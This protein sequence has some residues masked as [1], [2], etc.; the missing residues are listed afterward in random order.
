MSDLYPESAVEEVLARTDILSVI[1]PYVHLVRKGGR[2]FG[3]CPFHQEKSPSF[4]VS[5]ERGLFYCFGCGAGG[6]VLQFL[7]RMEGWS[8][9]EALEELAR[10]A[11]VRLARPNPEEQRRRDRRRS[12]QEAYFGLTEMATTFFQQ[13]L[14]GGHSPQANRYLAERGVDEE[15]ARLFRLGYAPDGW[16]HLLRFLRRNNLSERAVEAAGLAIPRRSGGYYDRFRDRIVF[17]VIDTL[18]RVVGFSARALGQVEEQKYINSPDLP[19]FKKGEQLFG[20]HAAKEHFRKEGEA[21][22]VEGNFDVVTL[23]AAG[24]RT[25]VAPLGTA[26]TAE[27]TRLLSRLVDSAVV[28]FDGDEAGRRAMMRCLEP[29]YR[30]GLAVRAALLPADTDPDSL[31]KQQGVEPFRALLQYARPLAEVVL[32]RA[33]TEAVG[34]SLEERMQAGRAA[35]ELLGLLPEGGLRRGYT[36]EVARRLDLP[37]EEVAAGIKPV[38]AQPAAQSGPVQPLSDNDR[39]WIQLVV[40]L[41]ALAERLVEDQPFWRLLHPAVHQL[42]QLLVEQG[43]AKQGE[44]RIDRLVERLDETTRSQILQAIASPQLHSEGQAEIAFEKQ[45]RKLKLDYLHQSKKKLAEQMRAAEKAG[46]E[47]RFAELVERDRDLTQ[48]LQAVK[49]HQP[50]L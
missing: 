49:R 48:E 4:S 21:V 32:D 42:A 43:L 38:K 11:G 23:H 29:C 17:P 37:I 18:G 28:V 47:R 27:Q 36:E 40:E 24:V 16:D 8:F 35:A 3:L 50:Y 31:V 12:E 2:Y 10:R 14:Q 22:L 45:M 6:S 7:M 9:G 25:A 41:P 15:T 46:D 26:L 34:G 5:A 19:F 1:E 39:L 30:S 20:I 44:M 33:I 13:Q